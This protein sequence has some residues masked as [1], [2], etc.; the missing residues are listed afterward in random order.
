MCPGLSRDLSQV[1]DAIKTA[2]INHE[3][4]KL[5]I[6]IAALQETRLPPNGS[7][8]EQDY[9]F[10]WQGREPG[11]NRIHGVGFAIRNS[12][13]SSIEPPLRGIARIIALR[14]STSTGPANMLSIYAPTLCSSKE[15]KDEFYEE[16][17]VITKEIP[18]AEQL[19]LLGTSL[20]GLERITTPGA[21]ASAT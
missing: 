8:R 3:L 5:N 4:R 17:E 7:I 15:E 1:D 13:L 9:T 11:E 6:D 14:L 19:Y 10:Y 12:S 18:A 16:V 2:I 21:A 20:L